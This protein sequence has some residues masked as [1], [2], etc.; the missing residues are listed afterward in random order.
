M[1]TIRGVFIIMLAAF[2]G[3]VGTSALAQPIHEPAKG[4]RERAEILD[5][6]RPTIEDEMRGPVEFVITTLRS[7]P[8]FAFVQADPQRPGGRPIDPEE[9]AFAGDA[10]MMDGLTVYA[11][12][13]FKS[14]G[15][16]LVEHVVGPT[17]VAYID[18]PDRFGAP[19]ALMGLD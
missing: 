17:D 8:R 16:Q 6:L 13:R 3:L 5:A 14:G 4:S 7:S 10:D 2:V 15:W 9:T 19:P 1:R 12:L 18:W 11:L